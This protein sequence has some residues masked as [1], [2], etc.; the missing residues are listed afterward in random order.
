MAETQGIKLDETTRAR[1]KALGEIRGK[2][3]HWLMNA[4]IES[5]LD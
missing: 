4:A 1:L 2:L 5:Y 3:P